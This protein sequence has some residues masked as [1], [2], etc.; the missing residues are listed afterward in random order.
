MQQINLKKNNNLKLTTMCMSPNCQKI[1]LMS[2]KKSS[3]SSK[4]SKASIYGSRTTP[5]GKSSARIT[6]GK[7]K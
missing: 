5:F 3:S 6:F 1:K 2:G 7:K 4:K